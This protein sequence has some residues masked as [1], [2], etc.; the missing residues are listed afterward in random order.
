MIAGVRPEDVERLRRSHAMAPLPVSEVERLLEQCAQ[1][2][3]ERQ[4]IAV[5][6]AELPGTVGALRAALNKLHTI[7][8]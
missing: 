7:V 1:M 3:R 2:A 4:Q 6:L 8:G 5:L